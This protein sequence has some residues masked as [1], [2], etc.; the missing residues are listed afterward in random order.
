MIDMIRVQNVSKKIK[1]N[2]V[3][4]QI[5]LELPRENVKDLWV[6]TVLAKR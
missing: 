6:R 4:D 2:C 5:H 1:R 3:L